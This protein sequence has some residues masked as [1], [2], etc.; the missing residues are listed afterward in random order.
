LYYFY[1]SS[2]SAN[3]G[4]DRQQFISLYAG[5]REVQSD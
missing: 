3:L 1:V 5:R 2:K 4:L